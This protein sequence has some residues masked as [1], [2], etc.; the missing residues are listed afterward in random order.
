MGAVPRVVR[1]AGACSAWAER[2]EGPPGHARRARL[3]AA[4]GA[5]AAHPGKWAQRCRVRGRTCCGVTQSRQAAPCKRPTGRHGVDP[6]SAGPNARWSARAGAGAGLSPR[7]SPQQGWSPARVPRGCMVVRPKGRRPT[8]KRS[9]PRKIVLAY[10]GGPRHLRRHPLARCALRRPGGHADGR[11]RAG[12]APSRRSES[13][14]AATGPHAPPHGNGVH[15][16]GPRRSPGTGAAGAG[17]HGL[18]RR[19][20]APQQSRAPSRGDGS[21]SCRVC[22]LRGPT[23]PVPPN[24]PRRGPLRTSPKR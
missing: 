8:S 24:P 2:R 23:L 19:P 17:A 5:A 22:P 11:P 14:P 20:V 9:M 16:P 21:A 18:P 4:R 3:R 7:W 15:P 1:A 6:W 12:A 10:S 13:G